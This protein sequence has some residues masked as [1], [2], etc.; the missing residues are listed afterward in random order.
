MAKSIVFEA[1]Q[2]PERDDARHMLHLCYLR[3]MDIGLRELRQNASEL[4]RRVERGETITVTVSGRVAARLMPPER[5]QWHRYDEIAELFAGPSDPSWSH[6]RDLI[7]GEPRDP[8][9]TV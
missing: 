3:A 6:D 7:D 9:A 2:P 8:W 5:R 4:V 1:R